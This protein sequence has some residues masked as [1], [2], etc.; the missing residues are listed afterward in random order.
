MK[1]DLQKAYDIV[2]WCFLEEMLHNVQLQLISSSLS[3]NVLQRLHF[4][5]WLMDLCKVILNLEEGWDK[6]AQCHLFFFAISI[7][8]LSRILRNIGT[9]PSS[10]IILDTG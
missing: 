5:S 2:N 8:Y 1:I 4:V 7:E 3:C 6:V 9:L 10:N